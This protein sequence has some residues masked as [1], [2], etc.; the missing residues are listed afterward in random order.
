MAASPPNPLPRR[1][2]SRELE[3]GPEEAALATA[4]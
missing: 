2:M 3:L 1:E 4:G